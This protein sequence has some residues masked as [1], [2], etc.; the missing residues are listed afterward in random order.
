MVEF[1]FKYLEFFERFG[2]ELLKGVFFYGLLGMG[3]IFLVK[4]VVNEVNVYF[5]VINGLEIMSKFYGESEERLREIFKEVE[6]NVLSII[7][8]DEIDVIVF[9]REEVVGEVEKRV[10]S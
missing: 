3:K 10:V 1:L 2:I 8:I 7:F 5:I 9:K 6:E 4:V